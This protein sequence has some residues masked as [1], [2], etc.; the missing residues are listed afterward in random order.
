[1]STKLPWFLTAF[2]LA[3]A[4][5]VT[6]P[7]LAEAGSIGWGDMAADASGSMQGL[8]SEA[9]PLVVGAG[10]VSSAF[11]LA[12]MTTTLVAT[13]AAT[14]GAANADQVQGL[15]G[16]GGAGGSIVEILAMIPVI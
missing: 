13:G 2:A 10:L 7:D 6:S 16:G 8:A 4:A 1:M 5:M 12:G 11:H 14:Y 15:V 9:V 3:L